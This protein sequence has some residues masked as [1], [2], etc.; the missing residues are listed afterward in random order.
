MSTISNSKNSEKTKSS[1][2]DL[3]TTSKPTSLKKAPAVKGKK[4]IPPPPMEVAVEDEV[5]DPMEK[6]LANAVSKK[7]R[8][9]QTIDKENNLSG[10]Y[11]EI[12]GPTYDFGPNF[13][14]NAGLEL[15]DMPDMQTYASDAG[16]Q[17]S[18]YHYTDNDIR[19]TSVALNERFKQDNQLSR[20]GGN[21]GI[22]YTNN[23]KDLLIGTPEVLAGR[24]LNLDLQ[25]TRSS[26]RMMPLDEG[27]RDVS[28]QEISGKID[29]L[30]NLARRN[31]ERISAFQKVIEQQNV[32]IKELRDSI[33]QI[34][35]TG[36]IDGE[37]V[38][39]FAINNLNPFTLG[40]TPSDFLDEYLKSIAYKGTEIKGVTRTGLCGAIKSKIDGVKETV[41]ENL[42]KV[43]DGKKTVFKV[44]ELDDLIKAVFSPFAIDSVDE[45]LKKYFLVYSIRMVKNQKGVFTVS[46]LAQS[47]LPS[48]SVLI[49]TLNDVIFE[50]QE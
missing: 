44:D 50:N 15:S 6:L 28:N 40:F 22:C 2:L 13:K 38:Q 25:K 36:V 32:E 12:L 47:S 14:S 37:A 34:N 23:D 45:R 43:F 31:D 5:D 30:I 26:L 27:Q 7:A 49:Q 46:A 10:F 8:N 41:R 48:S 29:I 16:I 20:M 33:G 35:L 19:N 9:M 11:N 39:E 42:R 1:V 4:K 21:N 3:L 24:N 18:S 17:Q